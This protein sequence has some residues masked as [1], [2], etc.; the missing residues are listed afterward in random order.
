MCLRHAFAID[1]LQFKLY[2]SIHCKRHVTLMISIFS[3]RTKLCDRAL[4]EERVRLY[5]REREECVNLSDD[6]NDQL[7]TVRQSQKWVREL[8][9]NI[10]H[11]I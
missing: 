9:E 8:W 3:L 6:A 5:R 2:L 7:Y 4:C 10:L 11:Y 1:V